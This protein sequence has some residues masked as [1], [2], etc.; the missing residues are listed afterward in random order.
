MII[1]KISVQKEGANRR[2]Y[3][4]KY[5]IHNNRARFFFTRE[6]ESKDRKYLMDTNFIFLKLVS[7]QR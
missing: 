6:R 1:Q 4:A 5:R 3:S 2:I 7:L